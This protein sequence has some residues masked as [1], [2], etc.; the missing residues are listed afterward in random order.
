ML[1]FEVT[2]ITFVQT[3]QVRIYKVMYQLSPFKQIIR[4]ETDAKRN[5][6]LLPLELNI[7]L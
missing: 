5:F 2:N 3:V 6:Q 1:G 4:G 7:A